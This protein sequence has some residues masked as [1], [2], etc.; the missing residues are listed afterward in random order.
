MDTQE[1]LFWLGKAENALAN[2]ANSSCWTDAD[3]GAVFCAAACGLEPAEKAAFAEKLSLHCLSAALNDPALNGEALLSHI[4]PAL[5]HSGMD[6]FPAARLMLQSALRAFPDPD[7]PDWSC[8]LFCCPGSGENL[9]LRLNCA[10]LLLGPGARIGRTEEY[11]NLA[12]NVC[13]ARLS[14][15]L[16]KLEPALLLRFKKIAGLATPL[17]A[18]TGLNHSRPFALFSETAGLSCLIEA[19]MLGECLPQGRGRASPKL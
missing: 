2:L 16:A 10:L 15:N 5:A 7:D 14:Q 1:M 19:A 17:A 13:L 4:A 12:E 18:D 6:C 11:D 8:Q 9:F 3:L